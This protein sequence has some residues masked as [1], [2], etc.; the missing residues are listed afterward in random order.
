M[1]EHHFRKPSTVDRIRANWLAPQIEHYIVWM[2]TQNYAARNIL[3]PCASS[4]PLSRFCQGEGCVRS[5]F[6]DLAGGQVASHWVAGA[7]C[8]NAA[9]RHSLFDDIRSVVLQMLRLTLEGRVTKNRAR[10]RLLLESEA[11]GFFQCYYAVS[12]SSHRFK[13]I[14]RG[15][16]SPH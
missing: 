4:L 13:L 12:F 5:H 3:R 10:P 2:Y 14:W 7:N 6:C 8:K 9:T 16:A 15:Y 1:L 11:P